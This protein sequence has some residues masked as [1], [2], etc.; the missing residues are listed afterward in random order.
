[1]VVKYLDS[2][3]LDPTINP[4]YEAETTPTSGLGA[5]TSVV[6]EPDLGGIKPPKDTGNVQ[7]GLY[8]SCLKKWE[9]YAST[10][11][12]TSTEAYELAKKEFMTKCITGSSSSTTTTTTTTTGNGTT[13]TTTG[14]T[15]TNV[16][17]PNLGGFLGSL[18][19]GGASGG[20][21]ATEEQTKTDCTCD[22]YKFPYWLIAV[23]VVGGYLI[24][25]KK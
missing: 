19:G 10:V 20:G 21:G 1:M 6:V 9:E 2:G 16:I 7:G 5:G 23:A 15:T 18:T 13:S 14:G 11:K 24:F 3:A 22:K 17:T 8:P 25:R 4:I 12:F